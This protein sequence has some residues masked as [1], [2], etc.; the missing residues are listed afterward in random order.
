MRVEQLTDQL[1]DYF[2]V[3]GTEGV[4]VASV[5]LDSAAGREGVKAGDVIIAIDGKSVSSPAEFGREMRAATAGS[6]RVLKIVCDK[7]E[8]EITIR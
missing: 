5:E 1:R 6:Q 8:R 7:Q 2:G 3:S 4:L